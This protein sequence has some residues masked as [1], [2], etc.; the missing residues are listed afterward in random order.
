MSQGDVKAQGGTPPRGG[1]ASA[2]IGIYLGVVQFFF[3]ATWVVYVIYLPQLAAQAGIGAAAARQ[4]T[5]M[6]V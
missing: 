1:P 2:G 4:S 5:A 3:A 6:T